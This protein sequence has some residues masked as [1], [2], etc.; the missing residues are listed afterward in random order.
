[1][2]G[3]GYWLAQL[4]VARLKAPLDAP[5]MAG[6]VDLLEPINALADA[7]PGF[8]WRHEGQHGHEVGLLGEADLLVNLSAWESLEALRDFTYGDVAPS[9]HSVAVRRRREW[10]T[11]MD[12]PHQA[13]WWVDEGRLPTLQDA[14]ARLLHLRHHRSSPYAFTFRTP[15]PAP[16]VPAAPEVPVASG[17]PEPMGRQG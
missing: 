8:V 3:R 2:A 17:V 16:G 10:F 6:F 13:M 1:M 5:E 9:P 4:N 12:G 15:Y 7:A 11:K 14:G